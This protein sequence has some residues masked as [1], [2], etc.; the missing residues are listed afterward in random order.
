MT[1]QPEAVDGAAR[2]AAMIAVL[3]AWQDD[4]FDA[5]AQSFVEGRAA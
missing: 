4:L 3:R 2:I 1:D 5:G